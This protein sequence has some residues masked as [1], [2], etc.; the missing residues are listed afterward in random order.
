[1][2]NVGRVFV[3]CFLSAIGHLLLALPAHAAEFYFEPAPDAPGPGFSVRLMMRLDAPVNAVQGEVRFDPAF[4]SVQSLSDN[5]SNIPFWIE[6]P[7]VAGTGTVGF[8]GI[9]PGGL[10]P[11]PVDRVPLFTATFS[12]LQAGRTRLSVSD[13]L[14]ML[15]QDPPEP[16][17]VTSV[18]LTVVLGPADVGEPAAAADAVPPEMFAISVIRGAPVRDGWASAVFSTRDLQT[19]VAG[20]ELRER[21]LGLPGDWHN[22]VSPASLSWRWP[23]SIIEVRATDVAGN[24]R[25]ARTVPRT[26]YGAVAVAVLVVMVA[27][28]RMRRRLRL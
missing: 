20:Y 18:P 17:R 24:E 10:Q 21:F 26:L 2:P 8:A 5:P 14:V 4:V 3:F 23:L 28:R 7:H 19:S 25:V 15:H 13:A 9:V 6:R 1:M 16:D 22:A 12:V 27:I 11:G